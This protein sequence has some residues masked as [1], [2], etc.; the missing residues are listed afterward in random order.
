MNQAIRV[1][2]TEDEESATFIAMAMPHNFT[3]T[4]SNPDH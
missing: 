4:E 2:L 3:F 1:L